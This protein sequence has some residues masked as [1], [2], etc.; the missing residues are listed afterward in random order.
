M[1]VVSPLGHS[2][3]YMHPPP[4]IEGISKNLPPQDKEDQSAGT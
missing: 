4:P 2:I 1:N 3:Y